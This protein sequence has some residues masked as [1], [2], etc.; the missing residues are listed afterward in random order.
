MP[1]PPRAAGPRAARPACQHRRLAAGGL[2]FLSATGLTWSRFAGDNIGVLRAHYGWSTPSVKT[3][4]GS[5]PAPAMAHDEHADHHG[6]GA[7]HM[8]MAPPLDPAT[9]DRVL[10]SARAAGIDA[11][12]L[13]IRPARSADKAWTVSEIDRR[14][15]TQVDAVAVDPTSLQ[16]VER[17][18]SPPY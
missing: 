14:W 10:A 3:T 16:V 7:M 15:P 2:L 18:S 12:K 11:G 17:N 5:A 8:T 13:E 9:F 6:H 1:A 4:L